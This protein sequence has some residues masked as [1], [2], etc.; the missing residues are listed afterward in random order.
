MVNLTIKELIQGYKNKHFSPVEV[1]KAYLN[2]IKASNP[3]LNAFIT[4]SEGTALNQ[5]QI[6]EKKLLAGEDIGALHGVP[7]SYKDLIDTKGIKTTNGSFVDR[8]QVPAQNAHVVKVLNGSEAINLGKTNLHEYAF[9]ITSNNPFYGPVRNPWD[10]SLI[11]GGSSGGSAAAVA[12]NLCLGSVGTDTGGSIRIPASCCGIVGLKPTYGLVSTEGIMPVSWSHD[13]AGPLARNVAD[14]AAIME[15]LTNASYE[16]FCIPDI[17]GLR[18]G[19]PKQYFNEQ[20]ED[21]VRAIFK[22]AIRELE[23]LGAIL[24]EIDMPFASDSLKVAFTVATAEA[25][26]IHKG[27]METSLA[28]YGDDIREILSSSKGISSLSYIEALKERETITRQLTELFEKVDVIVTPTMPATPTK[29]GV[30]EVVFKETTEDIF[31]CMIR[32]TC[33]FNIT[34]HPAMS[35]PCGLTVEKSLPAGLQIAA[36]HGREDLLIRIAYTYENAFLKDFYAKREAVC[37]L[38]TFI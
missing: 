23:S 9:G 17:K 20:I 30:E 14:L 12:A 35:I 29:I 34:G 26:Y 31:S 22:K 6:A 2:R 32:Y 24:I 1:T 10:T 33:L 21:E 36:N 4:V 8:E 7:F 19:V 15:A 13:H 5:A 38:K 3:A 27:K 28:L 11:A 37:A 18:V 16:R 25:G